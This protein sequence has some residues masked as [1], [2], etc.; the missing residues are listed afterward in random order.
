ML[1]ISLK[2]GKITALNRYFE[3]NQCEKLLNTNKE[4]LKINDIEIFNIVD[5]YLKNV[6]IKCGEIELEFENREKEYRKT[7]KKDLDKFLDK[8]IGELGFSKYLQKINKDDL[9]VSYD[10]NSLYPS[11]QIDIKSTWPKL[12]TTCPFAKDMSEII[13]SLFNSA[14]WNEFKRSAL[15]SVIYHNPENLVFQHLHVKEK[16]KNPNKTIG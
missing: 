14:R 9:L 16:N 6:N 15:L 7:L 2:G 12:E 5:E 4:L 10:F 3:S 13:C 8:K 11:A 1:R